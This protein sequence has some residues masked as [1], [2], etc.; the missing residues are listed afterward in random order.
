M[1]NRFHNKFHR[2]N[3]HSKRTTKNNTYADAGYDPIASFEVPFQGE[4]YSE[5]DILTTE[6]L[7]AQQGIF[8]ETLTTKGSVQ[9]GGDLNVQG[10]AQIN[11]DLTV[12][13]DLSAVGNS[14]FD[15]NVSIKQDLSAIG[16][17]VFDSNVLIKQNLNIVGNS[18]ID[19]SLVLSGNLTVLGS[20]VQLDTTVMA[21][22]ALAITNLGTG[23]ALT[24]TQYGTQPIA[25][26]I[27]AN[28]DDIIFQDNGYVG[29]G[30]DSPNEK[31]T[32]VGNISSVGDL[33]V[34][35]SVYVT[36]SN[37]IEG[38]LEVDSDVLFADVTNNLVGINTNTPNVELTLV[39]SASATGNLTVNSDTIL[40]SLS[41][42]NT[43]TINGTLSV[44]SNKEDS[45]FTV[46]QEG[47][48]NSIF[49]TNS[50]QSLF[51]IDS[52]GRV[53]I[54]TGTPNE[55]LTIVGNVSSTGNV[56]I[57]SNTYI[58][59]NLTVSQNISSTGTVTISSIFT[60]ATNDVVTKDSNN[61]LETRE[62]NPRVW[63][64][65]SNLLTGTLTQSYLPK[66]DTDSTLV[67]SN[68]Y[69]DGTNVGINTSSPNEALTI[70]GNVS[71]TGDL[72]IEGSEFVTANLTVSQNISSSGT[73]TIGTIPSDAT[74]DVIIKDANNTLKTQEINPR[75]WDTTANLL[76]G[77]LTQN[78]LPK[79]DSDSSLVNSI[80]YDNGTFVGIN[81]NSPTDTLTVQGSSK[82]FGN[83]TIFGDLTASG[84][85][86]FANTVFSTTSSLSVVHIGSGPAAWIGNDGTGDIAT[87]YDIDAG[88]EVLHVG[89]IN[90]DNPNVGIKTSTPNKDFTV[91]GE[92]SSSS[93]IYDSNGNS[94]NWNSVYSSV[95]STSASW[96]SVYSSVANTSG[97]WDSVYS[98][99][100]STSASWNST[101]NSVNSVSANWQSVY[102]SVAPTSASWNSVYSS[103]VPVSG[104]WNSVYASV[105]SAS[106]TWDSVYSS[107][108]NT[109][110]TWD[111]TY[112]SVANTSA[113]WDSVYSSVA[114][115]SADWQNTYTDFSTNSA[116]YATNSTVNLVSSQLVLT[117]DFD[118]YKTDVASAT[119]TL[120]QTSIYQ[121]ASGSW[122]SVYNSVAP[123]SANWQ[124]TYTDFSTNS[125]S[126]ATNS[127]VN[128][129]SSQLVLNT[130]FNSYK[131]DVASATATLLLTTVYQNASGN[132]Q[133]VYNTVQTNSATAWNYQ[134]T[135]IKALT[136]NWESTYTTFRD[137]SS[138]FLTSETDSQ[139]L[140]FDE[141]T[142]DLTISNGNTVSLS[143]F[144]EAL[145]NYLPLSGG[146]VTGNLSF[147]GNFEV[148]P[149]SG[150]TT[151]FVSGGQVGINTETP[152]EELT[153]VGDISASNI[154]YADGGNS[155][156]WN[157]VFTSYSSNSS[158]F[159]TSETDSQTLSFDEGTKDLSISN[160]N[161]V[162]L[163]ALVD[164]T[165]IDSGV[166][167]LTSVWDS[168]YSTVQTNSAS[169]VKT[170]V[171]NATP[172]LSAITKLVAVSAI[173]LVQE[174]GTL[175]VLI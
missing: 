20:A 52:A 50:A 110:A 148:G 162:S 54:A 127:T 164:G 86:T 61:T 84:I 32:V 78:Y 146:T 159:L 3:H 169:F 24:V 155:V 163:S 151:L 94:T 19:G 16:N 173:P 10:K 118:S 6:N 69:S 108:A 56:Y 57:D 30:T 149:S 115:T 4:F 12:K 122:Q 141:G 137:V 174:V 113:D 89:G 22:S 2:Q 128:S 25:H 143:S 51:V 9:V 167:A 132:W 36:G 161:T 39:G 47:T 28:G 82:F 7:S 41:S 67:N 79:F 166:R 136:S 150:S 33:I 38:N 76:S 18:T 65:T 109:S 144:D 59:Q 90:G 139:T 14:V 130:D 138:T 96:N 145:G 60:G 62:I 129:V 152:N 172:G 72:Y 131:T 68:V 160:G 70:V 1:S 75:V 106:A 45:A 17:S 133:N 58:Q 83:V 126:Y 123:V 8:S 168:T 100:A 11:D 156:S 158:T 55:A 97:T 37:I 116:L 43:T 154:I 112:S 85:S 31:L 101:Y 165:A 114:N 171:T 5:G 99:V 34:T 104:N 91:K 21:S 88:V 71:S 63:D 49:V 170:D 107:V 111:S 29:L 105:A 103:V 134:G 53:G 124:N 102:S 95:A 13:Q 40:G 147:E 64:T 175:Y 140:S 142:K 117:T 119:A 46:F 121:S 77:S 27:D 87:F 80:V 26:F 135:D 44:V 98:S 42:S 74:N 153:V 120:L 125:A 66:F 48:G 35:G 92:L 15:G 81:T 157:E 23:P 73:A 93:T